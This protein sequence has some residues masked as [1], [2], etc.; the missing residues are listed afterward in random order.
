MIIQLLKKSQGLNLLQKYF[1][2][3]YS[4]LLSKSISI[5]TENYEKKI[6]E[7]SPKPKKDAQI[8]KKKEIPELIM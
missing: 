5:K 2:Y 4:P 6:L 1:K 8:S 7:Q 3:F